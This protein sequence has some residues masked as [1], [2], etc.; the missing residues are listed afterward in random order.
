MR[1]KAVFWSGHRDKVC[2]VRLAGDT[3]EGTAIISEEEQ[4]EL[5]QCALQLADQ[6]LPPGWEIV[7]SSAFAHVACNREREIYFKQFLPRS[8]AESM[9]ALVRGSRATRARK[10]GE[11]MLRAGIDAPANLAWGKLPGGS[12]YLFSRAAPGDDVTRWLRV[13]LSERSGEQLQTRRQL[14]R[15]LGTCIGRVH[16]TGFVHG[17]LR[18]GNILADLCGERFHFTLIDNERTVQYSPP[19]GKLL[20]KNLMQLNMLSL[21]ELSR[22]DRMRFFCEWRQQMR[23]LSEVETKLLAR[24]AYQWAMRRLDAKAKR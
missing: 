17:D 15:A 24:E 16:A 19:A 13:A 11:A 9:K 23:V 7:Q 22:A 20:L 1:R 21:D 12:E 18:P 5:H 3:G 4:R 14:L 10:N 8:P 6:Q 2:R